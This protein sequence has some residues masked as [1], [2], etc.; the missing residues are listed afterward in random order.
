MVINSPPWEQ[1]MSPTPKLP[2]P[3]YEALGQQ[4]GGGRGSRYLRKIGFAETFNVTAD[5][6][7][8]VEMYLFFID[9]G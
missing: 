5:I 1:G 8:V 2:L 7:K 4:A 3:G 9:N 6:F